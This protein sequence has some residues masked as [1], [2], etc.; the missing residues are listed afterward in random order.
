MAKWNT[1]YFCFFS[2]KFGNIDDRSENETS[3]EKNQKNI[4]DFLFQKKG[5]DKRRKNFGQVSISR[6]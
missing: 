1:I 2:G 5:I 6:W 3:K 4:G